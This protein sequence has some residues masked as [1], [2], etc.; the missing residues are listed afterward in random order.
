MEYYLQIIL[1]LI[2]LIGAVVPLSTDIKAIRVKN[3]LAAI[4]VMVL[5]GFI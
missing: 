2:V 3:I 1:G 5:F 4:A